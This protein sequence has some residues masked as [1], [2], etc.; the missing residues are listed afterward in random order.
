MPYPYVPEGGVALSTAGVVK[1]EVAISISG[2]PRPVVTSSTGS[3]GPIGI[4]NMPVNHPRSETTAGDLTSGR[5]SERTC[6]Q[7]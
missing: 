2:A 1:H 5:P 4:L 3:P 7:E 6:L